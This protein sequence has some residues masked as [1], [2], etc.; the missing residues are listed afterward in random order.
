MLVPV[1]HRRENY[2]LGQKQ[3]SVQID[4]ISTKELK[5]RWQNLMSEHAGVL[6]IIFEARV[7]INNGRLRFDGN[8]IN[9]SPFAIGRLITRTSVISRPHH[10]TRGCAAS[11]CGTAIWPAKRSIPNS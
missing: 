8:L 4:Q 2:V 6:P 11:T 5:F 9:N 7:T 1:P 10:L 3:N